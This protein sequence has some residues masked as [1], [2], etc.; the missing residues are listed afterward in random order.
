MKLSEIKEILALENLTLTKSLGQ[1]FLHDANQLKKI[2][3]AVP[4][5]AG[6]RVLEIGPGLGP[7]TEELLAQG[8]TVLALEKDQRLAGPL[9]RRFADHLAQHRLDLRFVDALDFLRSDSTDWSGWKSISNLPYSVASPILVELAQKPCP[10]DWIVATL[11]L[12]V[13]KR[14]LA[15]PGNEDYGVLTLLV[16][17]HFEPKG[18]FKIPAACFHPTPEV[19][20]GC[21]TLK[22]RPQPLLD[23]PGQAAFVRLVKTGFSQRRKMMMK[24]SRGAWPTGRLEAAFAAV[25]ISDKVRAEA[26]ALEQFVALARFLAPPDHS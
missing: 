8:A 23:A 7:L 2:A 6:D 25:G 15:G 11:Q 17:L 3:G 26:L 20:S 1:N 16:G 4:L 14:F 13:V 22:K 10:P 18:W 12:E 21:I 5:A 9:Q 19:E 24:I